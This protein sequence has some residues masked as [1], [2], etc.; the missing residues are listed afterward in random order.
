MDRQT[1]VTANQKKLWNAK[2]KSGEHKNW[3]AKPN[4]FARGVVKDLSKGSYVL[5]IGCGG[6]ADARL[7]ASQGVQVLATD[8]A[9]EIIQQNKVLRSMP[10][11]TYEVLDIGQRL[12]FPDQRFN[13]IYAHL[14]LQYFTNEHTKNIFIELARVLCSEGRLYFTCLSVKDRL[15][16]EGEQIEPN[17]FVRKSHIRHFFTADYALELLGD[18]F[19]IRRL[20]TL[21]GAF[22]DRP[23]VYLACWAVKASEDMTEYSAFN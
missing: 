14:S 16:G 19:E 3:L 13:A 22:G 8:I 4:D 18:Q 10:H 12:G 21:E 9:D 15:F 23:S 2:Y 6:G 20:E 17:V 11:L 1:K 5:E 7:F